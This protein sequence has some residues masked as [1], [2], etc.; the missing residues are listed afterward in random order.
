MTTKP[1]VLI[2]S[3]L[4]GSGKSTFA[5]DWLVQKQ[6]QGVR[7]NYDNIRIELFGTDWKWNRTDE[8]KMKDHAMETANDALKCG[9]SLI[10][11]NTNL[12]PKARAP[13][14]NLARSYG[15]TP[16]NMEFDTPVAEC[17]RRDS[18]RSDR[19][20]VGRAV[21]E[22]FALFNG[23]IDWN[24]R[25]LYPRDFI[26]VDMDGTV[27]D[28]DWRRKLAFEG[29][30]KH[31]DVKIFLESSNGVTVPCSLKNKV[32]DRE[33]PECGGKARK[34]WPLFAANVE[35]DPPIQPIVSLVQTLEMYGGEDTS[36]DFSGLDVIVV[37]G[38]E[39]G[40]SGKGTEAW[41]EKMPWHTLHLFMRNSQDYR[42][43]DVIKQ[44]IL[45]L[46]PKDRIRYVLD[47]R[48]RVV[49]MWRRNG[50]ACLQVADGRF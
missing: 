9:Y 23:F 1:E 41:L 16:E 33:C 12:T 15:L 50:L 14:E 48:Q 13:W 25:S 31:K 27:A 28:C 32:V 4:P 35:N 47:D 10:I 21:I 30:T 37:S 18:L 19:S 49:D 24:D 6:G 22:R 7:I 43:D 29:P 34:N 8:G 40:P 42:P 11:D 44:E 2:L 45:D 38:R 17:V 20:R 39:I 36:G 5:E 46:L 26:I 3:G